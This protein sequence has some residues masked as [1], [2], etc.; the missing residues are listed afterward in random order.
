METKVDDE[1]REWIF[2]YGEDVKKQLLEVPY[3]ADRKD[4]EFVL[5]TIGITI[6]HIEHLE[7]FFM[8]VIKIEK[9][10]DCGQN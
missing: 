8:P 7:G 4:W 2:K 3:R 10:E 6:K 5:K 1:L 9:G